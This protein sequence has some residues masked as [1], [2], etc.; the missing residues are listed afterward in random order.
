MLGISRFLSARAS[1]GQR[2]SCFWKN[3]PKESLAPGRVK[4]LS[5]APCPFPPV[6][7]C[8]FIASVTDE[9]E[10]RA[11]VD[12]LGI[13]TLRR[14]ILL[15]AEP[16]KPRCCAGRAGLESWEY[17]KRRL[18]ELG[19]VGPGAAVFRTKAN[20]LQVCAHGPVAVVY[21]EGVWYR[22]CTPAVLETIIR[23]HLVHGRPVLEH[24]FAHRP[25]GDGAA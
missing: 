10:L 4:R 19:L 21:P 23:E 1:P 13:T 12:H 17:L 3:V 22:G 24:A 7:A 18:K 5:V 15:C 16:S 11:A 2:V 6:A 25:L 9:P 14:H 20:C 8:G